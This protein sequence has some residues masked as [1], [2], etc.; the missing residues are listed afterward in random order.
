MIFSLSS[1]SLSFLKWEQQHRNDDVYVIS[2]SLGQLFDSD[3]CFQYRIFKLS[4]QFTKMNL[5]GL[6]WLRQ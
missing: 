3:K 2:I 5:K 6:S 4:I 1:R